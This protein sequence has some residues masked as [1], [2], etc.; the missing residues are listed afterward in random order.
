MAVLEEMLDGVCHFHEQGAGEKRRVLFY[1][2]KCPQP[3]LTLGARKHIDSDFFTV[4]LQDHVGGL[5][6]LYQNQWID[7]GPVPGVLGVNI[8]DLLQ[9]ILN[10][11][12]KSSEHR[13]VTNMGPRVSAVC[14]FYMAM[15]PLPKLYGPIKELISVGD[16]VKTEKPPSWS[17]VP[18]LARKVMRLRLCSSSSCEL[19]SGKQLVLQIG[20]GMPTLA[21]N[22]PERDTS[23]LASL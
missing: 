22:K 15:L 23:L 8:G 4:L 10:D 1:Y 20:K 21:E 3:E 9:L 6:V 16:P 18:T 17:I 19:G 13:V 14:F 11:I 7:M 5:Q 12:F 2:P